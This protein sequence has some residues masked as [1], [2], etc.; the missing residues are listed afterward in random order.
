MNSGKNC[1]SR[2]NHPLDFFCSY[3]HKFEYLQ[4][5]LTERVSVQNNDNIDKVFWERE[6]F[7]QAQLFKLS[8][9]LNDPN[10]WCTL[11]S[12]NYKK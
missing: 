2:P 6:K 7:W 9:R 1:S 3:V 12:K 4:V 8:H 10:E 5:Q 11:N